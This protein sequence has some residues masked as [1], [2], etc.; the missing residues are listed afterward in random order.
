MEKIVYETPELLELD[1]PLAVSGDSKCSDGI[2]ETVN[3]P[4]QGGA[5][6]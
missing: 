5:D 6:N 4:C 3:Q 1:S 2:E